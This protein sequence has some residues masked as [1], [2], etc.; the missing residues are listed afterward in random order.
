MVNNENGTRCKLRCQC[1]LPGI[2]TN[3]RLK[4]E[5]GQ[6]NARAQQREKHHIIC[7]DSEPQPLWQSLRVEIIVRQ[8]KHSSEIES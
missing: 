3:H 4:G 5:A 2:Q 1:S 6:L 7:D 8:S